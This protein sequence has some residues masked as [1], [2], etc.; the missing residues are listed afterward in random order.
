MAGQDIDKEEQGDTK[1]V[2]PDGDRVFLGPPE[3][4]TKE[5]DI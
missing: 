3:C 2:F 4:G 5:T 1:A